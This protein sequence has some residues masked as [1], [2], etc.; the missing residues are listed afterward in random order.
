MIKKEDV[1]EEAEEMPDFLLNNEKPPSASLG[2]FKPFK[3]GITY[4]YYVD[5]TFF[6][7]QSVVS[8]K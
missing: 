7:F 3:V 4:P 5:R 1:K 2:D 6:I 8:G